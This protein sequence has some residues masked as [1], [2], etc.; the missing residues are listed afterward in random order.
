M[1]AELEQIDRVLSGDN[2]AFRELIEQYQA[3]VCHV[4]YRMVT[5]EADR[6]ELC[7]D[8]F[9]KVYQ[10]LAGF[11]RNSRLST[12]IGRIAYNTAINY[13]RKKKLP[14]LDDFARQQ[15]DAGGSLFERVESEADGPETVLSESEV[16]SMLH[17]AIHQLTPQYRVVV[18]LYHLD[19]LSYREIGDIMD[20]PEGTVKSYLFRGRKLLKETLL[21][22]HSHEE[23]LK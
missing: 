2:S 9:M 14:L 7:Q 1:Q 3:L 20:L 10:N 23:L 18:T 6:E 19:G 12:W 13:L 16:R 17:E 5:N 22:Q 15:D 4:I 8:V 21:A 11:R